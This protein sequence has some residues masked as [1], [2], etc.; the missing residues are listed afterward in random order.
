MCKYY[1]CNELLMQL[2][3]MIYNIVDKTIQIGY[4]KVLLNTDY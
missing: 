3:T 4:N 1:Y 2:F